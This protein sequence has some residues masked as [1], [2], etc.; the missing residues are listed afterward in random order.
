MT[1]VASCPRL[2]RRYRFDLGL[3]ERAAGGGWR[4]LPAGASPLPDAAC[5]TC[6]RSAARW[7]A[8][9]RSARTH[10]APRVRRR[11]GVWW[12]AACWAGVASRTPCNMRR[13]PL[14][15]RWGVRWRYWSCWSSCG[16]GAGLARGVHR[17]NPAEA[18]LPRW[19]VSVAAGESLRAVEPLAAPM[20]RQIPGRWSDPCIVLARTLQMRADYV[21]ELALSICRR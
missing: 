6:G 18:S 12:T 15:A 11:P 7:V 14:Q 13:R 1:R 19:R 4:K 10:A 16:G 9:N 3:L 17:G 20:T 21:R 2:P 5:R 8:G